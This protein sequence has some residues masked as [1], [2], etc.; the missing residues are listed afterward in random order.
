MK[1]I[2]QIPCLNEELTLPQTLAELPRSIPG[3]DVIEWLVIDDGSQDRTVEVAREL[4]VQHIVHHPV[5]KGLAAAF[6]SGLNAGLQLGADIIVNTDADNQYPGRYITELVQPILKGQADIVIGD[7]QTDTI[8]HF[9]PI[10]KRLQRFGSAVVRSVSGTD[11][12]DAPSGFRAWS[13]EAALRINVITGYT[14]TLETI[15]QAG[16][17]NLTIAT[18]PVTTNAKTRESRL[19]SSIP[20]YVLRSATTI[21]R[22]YMLYRPL[23][24]FALLSLPFF[25]TGVGLW[26]RYLILLLLGEAGRGTNVQSVI[27]G[28]AALIIGFIIFLIGLIGD[29]I[30]INR[31]LHEETLYYVK[32][33]VLL[34]DNTPV[35]PAIESV[36]HGERNAQRINGEGDNL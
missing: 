11:V 14:Y 33:S 5:N 18:V 15:I 1:L 26:V 23:R 9:S 6:Q 10:K 29:L 28:A 30:A 12:E 36:L 19:I 35:D 20:Q 24:T 3:I 16:H 4:G 8:E 2:I 25:I 7:R 27:V 34:A 31:R 21:L 13:R 22:L 17:R 32:R